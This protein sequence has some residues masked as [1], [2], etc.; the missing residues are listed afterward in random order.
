MFKH[1][2]IDIRTR[3][4]L[5]SEKEQSPIS[6]PAKSYL[7]LYTRTT[8]QWLFSDR[9]SVSSLSELST[10]YKIQPQQLL[11]LRR[12]DLIRMCWLNYWEWY[13]MQTSLKMCPLPSTD[14]LQTL[15]TTKSYQEAWTVCRIWISKIPPSRRRVT[16]APSTH[17]PPSSECRLPE[18]RRNLKEWT[19]TC[20]PSK[21]R[22]EKFKRRNEASRPRIKKAPTWSPNSLPETMTP[23]KKEEPGSREEV[24]KM[25]KSWKCKKAKN[26]PKIRDLFKVEE[27]SSNC[28]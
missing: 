14:P 24:E 27:T 5:L 6:K 17:L 10:S 9:T 12:V 15:T 28:N 4:P 3:N 1:C 16:K 7:L 8:K 25:Q 21:E 2:G 18:K 20:H 19:Q 22:K 26:R 11:S 13:R 23:W